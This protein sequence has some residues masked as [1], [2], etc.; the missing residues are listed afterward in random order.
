MP[1]TWEGADHTEAPKELQA[2][3]RKKGGLPCHMAIPWVERTAVQGW[4]GKEGKEKSL[5]QSQRRPWAAE[6]EGQ[7]GPCEGTGPTAQ[8]HNKEE[9]AIL[10]WSWRRVYCQ[11]VTP[12]A[13]NMQRRALVMR[14]PA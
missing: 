2:R 1:F 7:T 14:K 9:R 10:A 5:R 3:G 8:K 13:L 6:R 4:E 12:G 11:E